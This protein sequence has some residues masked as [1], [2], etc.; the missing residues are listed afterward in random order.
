ML[1]RS[2]ILYLY[3]KKGLVN[4]DIIDNVVYWRTLEMDWN[5]LKF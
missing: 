1:T 3:I 5:F 2:V 4:N